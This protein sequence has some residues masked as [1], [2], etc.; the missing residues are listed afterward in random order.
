MSRVSPGRVGHG[1]ADRGEVEAGRAAEGLAAA[2][3]V[4]GRCSSAPAPPHAGMNRNAL[5]DVV[6]RAAHRTGLGVVHAPGCGTALLPRL[7]T[8]PVT[9]S[10]RWTQ[11][12]QC[13]A[14]AP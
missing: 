11:P 3:P 10:G 6:A 2:A 7:R 8:P 14:H 5:T 12:P 9:T 1:G 4:P 13:L